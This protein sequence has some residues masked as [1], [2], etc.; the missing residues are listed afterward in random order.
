MLVELA[1][2]A[3]WGRKR[4]APRLVFSASGPRRLQEEIKGTADTIAIENACMPPFFT[5]TLISIERGEGVFARTEEGE[6]HLDLTA[7]WGV[8]SIGHAH[9]VIQAALAE[10]GACILQNPDSGLTFSPAGL[11]APAF[12]LASPD[13]DFMT[14]QTMLLV[15]GGYRAHWGLGRPR[16]AA[17]ARRWLRRLPLPGRSADPGVEEHR[18][19]APGAATDADRK[20]GSTVE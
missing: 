12:F 8:T 11:A 7:G 10:Q 18:H 15:D 19:E 1:F 16:K 17:I 4:R 5:K 9:P 6:G 20:R 14:G 13:G 2:P 3:P